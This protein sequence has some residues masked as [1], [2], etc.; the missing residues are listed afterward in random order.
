[1]MLR[2]VRDNII[3]F[4]GNPH[5]V[6]VMGQGTGAV[7][8]SYHLL[9]PM[10]RGLTRRAILHSG[11]P[12]MPFPRPVHDPVRT[13]AEELGCIASKTSYDSVAVARCLHY[14]VSRKML[15]HIRG[16]FNP[17]TGDAFLPNNAVELISS[18]ADQQG[19]VLMGNVKNEGSLYVEHAFRDLTKEQM[20]TVNV[21]EMMNR[22]ID[23]LQDYAVPNLTAILE[24]VRLLSQSLAVLNVRERGDVEGRR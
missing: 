13:A 22:L 3:S 15:K 24:C 9:S 23:H 17:I 5:N 16:Y 14:T 12:L 6:V 20:N 2:W 7:S 18:S 11:S 8:A 21:N 19:Q 10:S 4:N 1:M